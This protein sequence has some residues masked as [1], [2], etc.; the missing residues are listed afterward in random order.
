M[1]ASRL[2]LLFAAG[3]LSACAAPRTLPTP[4]PS[5]KDL[6]LPG[7]AFQLVGH[8]AFLIRPQD[9]EPDGSS[10]W[11]LYAPTLPG[12]P[13]QAEVW[14]F[15]RFLAAGIAIA[16][17]DVGESY[18]SPDG[19]ALYDLLYEHMVYARGYA[20]KA[21]LLARSRG[22]L[23]TL[24]WGAK[25]PQRVA[26]F[27]GIY[28]VCDLR[29]YPGLERAAA[30]HGTSVQGLAALLLERN[31]IDRVAPLVAA[32]VPFFAVH[33]DRDTVVP[34]EANSGA[35]AERVRALGGSMELHL[36]P[37]RGHDMDLGFFQDEQ[38]VAFVLRHAR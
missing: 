37:G 19:T 6:P 3:A 28:P 10:P 12:L 14:M 34:L 23:M 29:S 32:G 4:A 33:G 13:S 8:D 7:E 35:L 17:I 1:C 15:E 27:A 2:V 9:V 31:P 38:L 16:G 26:A 18:G 25:Q 21:V 24:A 11:V 36:L 30:A 22:G 20:P 5:S